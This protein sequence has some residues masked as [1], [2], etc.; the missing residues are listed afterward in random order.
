MSDRILDISNKV[1]KVRDNN[2]ILDAL[3][4]FIPGVGEAQDF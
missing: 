1:K 4:G 2:P 3:A